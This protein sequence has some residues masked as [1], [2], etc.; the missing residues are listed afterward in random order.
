MTVSRKGSGFAVQTPDGKEFKF[1]TIEDVNNIGKILD[2]A[3]NKEV[4]SSFDV[5]NDD[6]ITVRGS[7]YGDDSS[8]DRY[9]V[10]IQQTNGWGKGYNKSS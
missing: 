7:T 2:N 3:R 4:N 1:D 9:K 5:K 8:V 10:T 6:P